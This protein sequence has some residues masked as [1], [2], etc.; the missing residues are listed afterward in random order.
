MTCVAH[1]KILTA[2]NQA[3]S[4]K[5]S[6]RSSQNV[7]TCP[8]RR[9]PYLYVVVSLFSSY[10]KKSGVEKDPILCLPISEEVRKYVLGVT[11]SCLGPS[12][13][14]LAVSLVSPM[15][16]LESQ[17]TF[18]YSLRGGLVAGRDDIKNS[19]T[20]SVFINIQELLEFLFNIN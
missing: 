14:S 1:N 7:L 4:V 13:T 10:R 18:Y 15:L 19:S 17:L 12:R 11:K 16:V 20:R 2:T 8:S 3:P 9:K 6:I 5:I